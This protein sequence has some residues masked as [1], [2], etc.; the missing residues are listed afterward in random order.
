MRAV[1]QRVSEAR[2]LV[3]G[4]VVG[5][6]GDGML[7]LVG[8][9]SGDTMS[10]VAALVAKVAGLRIFVD[11]DMKMNRSITD[12][13]GSILVVSQFTLLA[14]VRRGRRPS[15]VAAASPADAEPLIEAL[16]QEFR[17]RGITVQEGAFGAHM[18]VELINDGPVT[19]ILDTIDGQIS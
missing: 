8:V 18:E 2:V 5:G 3:D 10:D 17:Q 4:A 7:M 16:C 11:D 9:A 1:I 6:I 14:D 12:T 15:F 13:R 19:I